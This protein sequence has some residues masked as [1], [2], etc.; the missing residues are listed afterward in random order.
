MLAPLNFPL[1]G[2]IRNLVYGHRF[3]HSRHPLY[4]FYLIDIKFT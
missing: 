4:D 1:R 2:V 3:N